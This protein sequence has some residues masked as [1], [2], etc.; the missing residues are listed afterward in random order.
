VQDSQFREF[1]LSLHIRTME[2]EM[3]AT[4]S[5]HKG[6]VNVLNYR[7]FGGDT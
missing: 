5:T 4:Y 6:N 2:D 1:Y 3:G 7:G